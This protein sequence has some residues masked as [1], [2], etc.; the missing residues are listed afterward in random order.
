MRSVEYIEKYRKLVKLLRI[1]SQVGYWVSAV[2]VLILLPLALYLSARAGIALSYGIPENLYLVDGVIRYNLA[3]VAE[4]VTPLQMTM[5]I[6]QLFFSIVVYSTVFG[7][8]LFYLCGVLR[9]VENG[10]PFDRENARRISS[11]GLIFL[12]GSIFI[13]SAQASSANT[14]IHVLG[15]TDTMSV[16]YSLNTMMLFAGLLL[17]IL[18]SVFRYGSY[19]QEEYDA[20][21]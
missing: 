17:L 18:S 16:N 7:L 4:T 12:V 9:M 21:L 2:I 20:T 10:T 6:K 1:L 13:G 15:L 8:I 5:I 19:L 3:L 14:I 11:I